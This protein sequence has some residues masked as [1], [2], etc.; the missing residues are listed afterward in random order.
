MLQQQGQMP[1]MLPEYSNA[2]ACHRWSWCRA[3]LHRTGRLRGSRYIHCAIDSLRWCADHRIC[4][5]RSAAIVIYYS[6]LLPM[7]PCR[8]A[9]H[10]PRIAVVG[11]KVSLHSALQQDW[12]SPHCIGLFDYLR[13]IYA[14]LQRMLYCGNEELRRRYCGLLL[15]LVDL[16]VSMSTGKLPTRY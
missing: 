10:F 13:T 5:R 15:C 7:L 3:P 16:S 9:V 1:T 4:I 2:S 12:G 6:L 8:S 11:E 14:F